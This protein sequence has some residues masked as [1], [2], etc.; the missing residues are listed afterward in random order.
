MKYHLRIAIVALWMLPLYSFAQ[1]PDLPPSGDWDGDGILNGD[2]ACC[3]T[4]SVWDDVTNDVCNTDSLA[5]MNGNGISSKEEGQCCLR[6]TEDATAVALPKRSFCYQS[7]PDENDL[8]QIE[9]E[10]EENSDVLVPCDRLL[11]YDGMTVITPSGSQEVSC[12]KNGCV[13]YTIGDYDGD[14]SSGNGSHSGPFDNCPNDANADGTLGQQLDKDGDLF[15]DKCEVC[16]TS[17][18]SL[19]ADLTNITE[20]EFVAYFE[21]IQCEIGGNDCPGAICVPRAIRNRH[22]EYVSNI[23]GSGMFSDY[24]WVGNL[25]SAPPDVDEDGQGDACDN[26]I[27]VKNPLQSDRDSDEVGDLCDVCPLDS[28]LSFLVSDM[29]NSDSDQVI[30]SCDNCVAI[31]NP[32]QLDNDSDGVGNRCDVCPFDGTLFQAVG[33]PDMDSDGTPNICDPCPHEFDSDNGESEEAVFY[34]D[35]DSDGYADI[36]DN[37]INTVNPG[38]KDKDSDGIGDDCQEKDSSTEYDSSSDS[39]TATQEQ[40]KAEETGAVSFS[41]GGVISCQVGNASFGDV[42]KSLFSL[43]QLV[44][45]M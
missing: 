15:G 39:D 10:C 36:C 2:D 3:F 23:S 19:F 43:L 4:T 33:L 25:C 37:C 41:G 38:Q 30:D 44:L 40:P 12:E 11:F 45:D 42:K 27:Q 18:D 14:D 16:A 32:L 9:Y 24:I 31:Y 35:A 20:E 5:D 26:C 17:V 34:P 1:C 22:V 13:C 29:D 7:S 28:T 6:V 21:S 8:G